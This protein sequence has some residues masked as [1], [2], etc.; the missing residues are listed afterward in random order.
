VSDSDQPVSWPPALGSGV[1]DSFWVND[2]PMS[3]GGRAVS[4]ERAGFASLAFLKAALRRRYKTWCALAMLGLLVGA[5][6]YVKFPQAYQADVSVF[7]KDGAGQDPAQQVL[8]DAAVAQSDEVATM[9]LQ[10]LGL[11]GDAA[12]LL[13]SYTVSDVTN[14]VLMFTVAAP[15]PAEALRNASAITSA[16]LQVRASYNLTQEQQVDSDLNLQVA[17]AQQHLDSINAQIGKLEAQPTSDTQQADLATQ[18]REQTAAQGTLAT[19]QQYA[20]SM[21]ATTA[22]STQQMD[23]DTQ[24]INAPALQKRSK[25][26]RPLFYIGGGLFGGLALGMIIVL[27]AALVSDRLR[28]RDDV[29][30]AFGAPVR[31]STG[32]VRQRSLSLSGRSSVNRKRV[33]E[34]L[35]GVVP[36]RANTSP[37]TLGIVAVDN[38]AEVAGMVVDLAKSCAGRGQRVAVVDLSARATVA[39]VLGVKGPG[40]RAVTVGGDR[41]IVVIPAGEE[42]A[43]TGPFRHE[44]ERVP[45]DE[46]LTE[47]YQQAELVLTLAELDP[48]VGAEHL[49]SWLTDVVAIVTAGRSSAGRLRAVG[50]MIR[51][52]EVYLTSVV[53]I[54]TDETDESLGLGD[55]QDPTVHPAAV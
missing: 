12:S 22:V 42:I 6:M 36:S 16:F 54:D 25:Y 50:E 49:A 38:T 19:T 52:T 26:K 15:K 35:A 11:Q 44:K 47:V 9:A 48:A 4:D 34:Y 27:I 21:T 24:V 33:I 40:I 37:A 18:R 3:A 1:S 41:L 17:Q 31:F 10:K 53:L 13:G 28:R 23:Q 45:G 7:L 14:Q 20:Q 51:L 29:A 2:E 8:T 43:P 32:P 5:A 39:G 55:W 46:A 30:S